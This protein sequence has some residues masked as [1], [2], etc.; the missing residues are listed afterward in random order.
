MICAPLS[1]LA[2][3]ALEEYCSHGNRIQK[4]T[5]RINICAHSDFLICQ[6]FLTS[7]PLARYVT[8]SEQQQE[9]RGDSRSNPDEVTGRREQG[10]GFLGFHGSLTACRDQGSKVSRH[11]YSSSTSEVTEPKTCCG[12]RVGSFEFGVWK[13][14]RC[15]E[16]TSTLRRIAEKKSNILPSKSSPEY[17][18]SW[19]TRRFIC[20]ERGV[21]LVHLFF[22][23]FSS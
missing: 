7:S 2:C 11:H 16:N 12:W 19:K 5:T 14:L 20:C 4:T 18:W 15:L 10:L 21:W 8:G 22:F 23:F 1:W 3:V 17:K 13:T 6:K 9:C